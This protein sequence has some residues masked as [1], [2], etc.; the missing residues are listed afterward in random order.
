MMSKIRLSSIECLVCCVEL[1][2]LRV[3]VLV[4]LKNY[5]LVWL[6]EKN[7]FRNIKDNVFIKEVFKRSKENFKGLK[8]V[9]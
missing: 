6:I 4:F 2:I 9:I 1:F 7:F 3:G 5:L 8:Y